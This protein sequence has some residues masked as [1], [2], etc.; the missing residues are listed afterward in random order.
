MAL[1]G[2]AASTNRKPRERAFHAIRGLP[3]DGAISIIGPGMIVVGDVVT[4]GIVRIEGEVKGTIRA[5]KA[6]ILGATGRIDG[7]IFTDEAVI[8][9]SVTGTI[10]ATNRLELQ[11]SCVVEGEIHARPQHLVLEEG[12]RFRGEVRMTETDAG[13]HLENGA[14]PDHTFAHPHPTSGDRHSAGSAGS[15]PLDARVA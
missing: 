6:V 7:D 8:G 11:N 10:V 5:G 14:G 13:S 1:F 4:E 9:G 15:T 12:A 2:K 3:M